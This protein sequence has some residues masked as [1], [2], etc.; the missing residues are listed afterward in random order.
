M[1]ACTERSSSSKP[2]HGDYCTRTAL[3]SS[4]LASNQAPCAVKRRGNYL[5]DCS[6]RR[7]D[8]KSCGVNQEKHSRGRSQGIQCLLSAH[9][10]LSVPHAS[11][12]RR[13][14]HAQPVLLSTVADDC[15]NVR[16][17]PVGFFSRGCEVQYLSVIHRTVR[18]TGKVPCKTEPLSEPKFTCSQKV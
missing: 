2:P 16:N 6:P 7:R 17:K 18:S 5:L 4:G 13:R 9:A 10:A 8:V 14:L 15:R 3:L 11:V 1:G 12:S